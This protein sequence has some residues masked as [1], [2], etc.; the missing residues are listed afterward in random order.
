MVFTPRQCFYL[1]ALV[2]SFIFSPTAIINWIW[3]WIKRVLKFV[4]WTVVALIVLEIAFCFA[5]EVGLLRMIFG[6]HSILLEVELNGSGVLVADENS[7]GDRIHVSYLGY[8]ARMEPQ[9]LDYFP[10]HRVPEDQKDTFRDVFYVVQTLE[11]K[12]AIVLL[13]EDATEENFLLWDQMLTSLETRDDI[14]WYVLEETGLS[15]LSVAFSHAMRT[16]GGRSDAEAGFDKRF[17]F[18]TRQREL[19]AWFKDLQTGLRNIEE[20]QLLVSE[21]EQQDAL[22]NGIKLGMPGGWKT[23]YLEERLPPFKSQT[24]TEAPKGVS[25]TVIGTKKP[26]A[27]DLTGEQRKDAEEKFASSQARRNRM[28]DYM[29][30]NPPKPANWFPLYSNSTK[31]ETTEEFLR[32][33]EPIFAPLTVWEV[34]SIDEFQKLSPEMAAWGSRNEVRMMGLF[35]KQQL[36]MVELGLRNPVAEIMEKAMTP[37]EDM[38]MGSLLTEELIPRLLEELAL[39]LGRNE[40]E[41]VR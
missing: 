41:H 2:A 15:S 14:S 32:M 35:L 21:E 9:Y 36:Y 29:R 39:M 33:F 31:A 19:F 28:I 12:L 25:E 30:L 10:Y 1:I 13:P 37:D 24:P 6:M 27:L 18:T 20:P 17:H 3:K 7:T 40:H 38:D 4:F 34:S 5:L 23:A 8:K 11:E 26:W 22:Q 16:Y